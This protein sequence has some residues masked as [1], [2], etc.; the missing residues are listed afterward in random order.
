MNNFQKNILYSEKINMDT[1]V[2]NIGGMI[3]FSVDI[4]YEQFEKIIVEII[5]ANSEI[6]LRL[7]KNNE[8]YEY[9]C[10]KYNI[11]HIRINGDCLTAAK[12]F[13]KIPFDIYDNDLFEFA[14]VEYS[15]GKAGFLKLHHLIGDAAS[16]V[17]ICKNIEKG[18]KALLDNKNFICEH[19]ETVYKQ[20]TDEK[21]KKASEYFEKKLYNVPVCSINTSDYNADIKKFSIKL[22]HKNMYSDFLTA[23]YIYL[24]AL[25]NY[26]KIVIGNVFGNR[27]KKEFDMFGMFV[28]TLPIVMEFENEN[29]SEISKK[30]SSELFTLMKYSGYSLIDLK[31]YN[32]VKGTL[33]NISVSYKTSRFLPEIDIGEVIEI[34]NGYCD[35]P[36]RIFVEEYNDRLDFDIHYKNK[37]FSDVQIENMGSCIADILSGNEKNKKI[38]EISVLSEYDKNI[39]KEFNNTYTKHI[40][41]DIIECFKAH[42]S[43]TMTVVFGNYSISGYELDEKSDYTA[44]MLIKKSAELVGIKIERS[45]EMIIAVIGTLKSGA[46]FII[47]S[48]EISGVL[49]KCDVILMKEDILNLKKDIFSIPVYNPENTAYLIYTSGS[50]GAP[51]CVEISRKSL[52]ARLEWANRIF[53]LNGTILQKTVNT[54]DVSIWEMLSVIYGAKLFLLKSGDEKFPDKIAEAITKYGIEKLHFVPSMLNIFIRYAKFKKL[55]FPT[56]KAVFSSGEKLEKYTVDNFYDIFN[57]E[58]YN[59]Y[60]PSECTIDVSYHKCEKYEK[61][62]PIGTPADNTQIYIINSFGKILPVDVCGEIVIVG[63]F[64]GKG[65]TNGEN[66]GFFRLNGKKA[67]KTGDIGKIGYDGNLY[68]YGRK[69]SQIKIRG[70]KVDLSEIKNVILYCE[71]VTDAVVLKNNNRLECFYSGEAKIEDIKKYMLNKIPHYAIPSIFYNIDE[72]PL[73]SV[74]KVDLKALQKIHQNK[75]YEELSKTEKIILECVQK[76]IST[77]PYE[78]LFEKGLDSLT[79]LDIVCELEEKGI[80]V[81]FGNFYEGLSVKGIASAIKNKNYTVWLKKENNEKLLICFPYAGGEPQF[82]SKLAEKLE[83]D[84][85]GVYISS[86]DVKDSIENI[87]EKLLEF[88]PLNLYK[89]IYVYGHCIGCMAAIEFSAKISDKLSGIILAAPAVSKA[90]PLIGSPWNMI[91]DKMIKKIFADNENK[92]YNKS[93]V[94]KFRNDTDRYFKYISNYK[95]YRLNC[96]SMIIFGENDIFTKNTKKIIKKL[97]KILYGD[98]SWYFI[99]NGKHFF[100]ETHILEVYKLISEFI[101]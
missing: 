41:S 15:G 67:Y 32:N 50:S 29:F 4:L 57:A 52:M 93:A 89:E 59:L 7:N 87:V 24:S 85:I 31:K 16:I 96:K 18:Y 39:Y 44:A 100:V 94:L 5:R 80:N 34:F 68:I 73:T 6:R 35:L 64:V 26:K 83:C 75:L 91:P 54:F 27:I 70:M 62:I 46:A 33:Y 71:N 28:N 101:K 23:L 66:G 74:G 92:K 48:D 51:K 2:S 55:K 58:L 90:I 38:F 10:K 13:I 98:F 72:I 45:I 95:K 60:G 9:K 49:E 22:P 99:K 1:P 69:D 53:G 14:F 40:Y 11:K 65:Y 19:I 61:E 30:I 17:L 42:I 82:F 76:Y 97:K 37:I 84:T 63:E 81:T 56:V 3:N 88:L 12:E 43:D 78:N 25:T 86:F 79:V 47:V 20:L 36:M 21:I 8:L 77:S